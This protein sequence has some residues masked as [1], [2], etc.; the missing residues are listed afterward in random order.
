[1][2]NLLAF[3]SSPGKKRLAEGEMKVIF[4]QRRKL[5]AI[6]IDNCVWVQIFTRK[7]LT[8]LGSN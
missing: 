2:V 4:L 5:S 3:F 7:M 6:K 8:R 1:M